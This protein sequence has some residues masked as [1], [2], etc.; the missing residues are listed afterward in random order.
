MLGC[1]NVQGALG[2]LLINLNARA[3]IFRKNSIISEWPLLEVAVVAAVTAII[4]YPVSLHTWFLG[5]ELY[6]YNVLQLVFLRVQSSVLVAD[7]F[8][9]CEPI[10][11]F[12]GLCE[13]AS[14]ALSPSS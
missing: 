4:S 3:A 7:L 2:S 12:Y 9:E 8:Q 13:C 5:P 11:N 6:T 14:F 10:T 1:F